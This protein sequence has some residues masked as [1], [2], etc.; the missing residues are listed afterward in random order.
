ME[1]SF[2]AFLFPHLS[3]EIGILNKQFYP[4]ELTRSQF[5]QDL[6]VQA[7][8]S[9]GQAKTDQPACYRANIN[10]LA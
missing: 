10:S 5:L 1:Q 3:G 6:A 9:Q 7:H 2:Q 8:K 4:R